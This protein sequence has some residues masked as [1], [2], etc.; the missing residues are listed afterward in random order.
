M[1]REPGPTVAAAY[2]VKPVYKA[3]RVLLLLQEARRELTLAEL[4]RQAQLPKS[5]V[6][7]YL[8]TLRACGFVAHDSASD[9]YRLGLRLWELARAVVADVS[10]RDIALPTMRTLRDRFNETINLGLLDGWEIVYLEIAESRHSLRMRAQVGGRDPAYSTSVGK[11]LLSALPEHQWAQHLPPRLVARTARTLTTVAAIRRELLLTHQR[12]YA[13]D[14]GE[15]E[16][17]C[18][19]VGVPIRDQSGQA[20]A[21]ISLSAPAN[22]LSEA[23]VAEAVTALR[24]AAAAISDRMGFPASA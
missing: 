20:A 12:G 22:R 19:C 9:R 17:Q 16:E 4:C 14:R 13:L 5:T 1:E 24:D 2:I 21:A 23:R 6:F 18:V 15:N 11:A 10:V 8:Q 3:L 7:K